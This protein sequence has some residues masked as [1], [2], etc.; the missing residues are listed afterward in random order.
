MPGYADELGQRARPRRS[1]RLKAYVDNWR[2]KGVPFYLRTGKRMPQ[3]DTEI[4]IQFRDVP[5]SIF[6]A[7]G[8]RPG[9]TS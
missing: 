3:R 6:A 1:L 5:Y 8:R 2:W 9:R 7:R 4:F